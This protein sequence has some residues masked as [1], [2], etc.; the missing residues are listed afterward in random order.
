DGGDREQPAA[1]L[2][3]AGRGADGELV[4]AVEEVFEV[5][6]AAVEHER[7]RHLREARTR[8]GGGRSCRSGGGRGR[9]RGR[10]GRG[11]TRTGTCDDRGE[12]D[13]LA[14]GRAF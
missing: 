2:Q 14:V 12:F 3:A 9:G 7:K 11:R 6:E 1:D 8:G 4:E 13:L 10:T 5:E